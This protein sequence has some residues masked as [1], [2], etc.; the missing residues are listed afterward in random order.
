MIG[1]L[2]TA[3]GMLML[4]SAGA[5]AASAVY[6]H[7]LWKDAMRPTR[8]TAGW[9]LANGV[10]MHP[11]DAGWT[12]TE[13]AF[14]RAD[15]GTMPAWLVTG[16]AA[17]QTT[18]TIVLHGHS[19]SRWDSLRR[20]APWVE[21]SALVVLPDLRGH[22]EAAGHT[23]L[24]RE[25]HRDVV[26]MMNELAAMVPG[27]R[28]TLVGHSLGAVVA[29]H[30][31]AHA[32]DSGLTVDAVEAF[33]PYDRVATPLRARLASRGLPAGPFVAFLLGLLNWKHGRET[34]THRAASRLTA[35]LTVHADEVDEVSPLAEA[36]AI[37]HAARNAVLRVS[38]GVPHADLGVAT[39]GAPPTG[40]A[41]DRAAALGAAPPGAIPPQAPSATCE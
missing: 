25:E 32:S 18:V 6:M 14:A 17:A 13:R 12:A 8:R 37:A 24:G 38:T 2:E 26:L 36:Q 3:A 39:L 11:E 10:P 4:L 30:A 15:G 41:P 20:A 40:A 31:A 35:P 1:V 9:A 16:R 19:R 21:R 7:G 22:G 28:F 27:A 29:V 5:L 23:A 33:G 34:P